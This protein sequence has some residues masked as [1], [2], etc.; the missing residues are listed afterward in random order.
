ML[1]LVESSLRYCLA[2][3]ADLIGDPRRRHPVVS[4]TGSGS[5]VGIV[6]LSFVEYVL[7]VRSMLVPRVGLERQIVVRGDVPEVG[8]SILVFVG[9]TKHASGEPS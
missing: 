5:P 6:L 4:L 8:V 1:D 7:M 9:L 2:K 3:L